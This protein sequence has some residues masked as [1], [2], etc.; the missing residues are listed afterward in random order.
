MKKFILP[1]FC[2][3]AFSITTFSQLQVTNYVNKNGIR[4]IAVKGDSV[5]IATT[6]GVVLRNIDGTLI[7]TYTMDEGLPHNDVSTVFA[8]S[9]GNIWCGTRGGVVKFDE[10]GMTQVSE[11]NNSTELIF[12]DNQGNIWF[13]RNWELIKY[14]GSLWTTYTTS[15]GLYYNY[16]YTV[17]EDNMG[18]M[19]FGYGYYE[20]GVTKFDGTNWTTYTDVDGLMNK[21]VYTIEEDNSG[22]M[23]FG[24]YGGGVSKFDGTNWIN[25]TSSDSLLGD[26]IYD[27]HKDGSGNLWFGINGAGINMYDGLTWSSFTSSDSL[28]SN[29]NSYIFEDSQGNLWFH[30]DYLDKFD[31]TQFTNYTTS[32]GL[33]GNG[34]YENKLAEDQT[35]NLWIGYS[36]NYKGLDK[37]D[38]STFI[39]Y[40]VDYNINS[41][42][43]YDIQK[44]HNGDLWFAVSGA[45]SLLKF[46]GTN[47]SYPGYHVGINTSSAY[48][49]IEDRNNNLW[50]GM[51]SNVAKWD[52]ASWTSYNETDGLTAKRIESMSQ[53]IAGNMWFGGRSSS[54]TDGVNKYDGVTW[55]TYTTA[56]GLDTSRV[57]ALLA[58]SLGNVWF[59][60]GYYGTGVTKYDGSAWTVITPANGIYSNSVFSILEDSKGNIW[61]GHDYG[62]SKFDG[63]TWTTFGSAEGFPGGYVYDITEDEFGVL[64]FAT[65]YGL[66]KYDSVNW[67]YYRLENS[68]LANNYLRAIEIDDQGNKWVGSGGYGLSV[69]SCQDP[70]ASFTYSGASYPDT[71]EFTNTSTL[72]DDFSRYEWDINDDGSIDYTTKNIKHVFMTPGTYQVQLVVLNDNCSDTIIQS[73]DVVDLS[74]KGGYTIGPSGD[75]ANFTDA[76]ND[77]IT[78]GVGG[79]VNFSVE[80]GNYNEQVVIPEISGASDTSTITFYPVNQHGAK[81]DFAPANPTENYTLKLDGADYISFEN[82]IISSSGTQYARVID[83]DNEASNNNFN[84]NQIIGINTE[85]LSNNRALV[86]S[87]TSSYDSINVF[88]NNTFKYGSYGIYFSCAGSGQFEYGNHI[89]GNEFLNQFYCALD[90]QYQNAPYVYNNT[91]T[92]SSTVSFTGIRLYGCT[93]YID[94]RK[95][96]ISALNS[97]GG[98]GLKFSN[99]NSSSGNEGLIANNFIYLNSTGSEC[100]GVKVDSSS[101]LNY[102][103]NTINITG[104]NTT[105]TCIYLNYT[106]SITTKNNIISNFAK[107]YTFYAGDSTDN[108][109]SDYNCLFTN[110]TFIGYTSGQNFADLA[111]LQAYNPAENQNCISVDPQYVS[112]TDLHVTNNALKA[113]TYVVDITTDIDGESRD[114]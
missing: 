36:N 16:V 49:L 80:D 111:A 26:Y 32:N 17:F 45:D 66:V 110:G 112:F 28:C 74:L 113:G 95:N 99:T 44:Y 91:I 86:Y 68:G 38:G 52:G 12:E 48:S 64:W 53:D 65:D 3:F 59:G 33:S 79:H 89:Y 71:V 93:D 14:D 50:F 83:M 8:D 4:G 46:D 100:Y 19:W 47:W 90:I 31:G 15:D 78:Y 55:T 21:M 97:G 27:I 73:I 98:Y 40:I 23:W 25:Y 42:Y 70:V 34:I 88:Q 1:F 103:F 51:Y 63:S 109:W 61:L 29:Y 30:G 11:V 35:G 104:N 76:V 77:L 101:C 18:N 92:T 69:I 81:L 57:Y 24:T 72:V 43:F 94:I 106:D 82:L 105:S 22:N 85:S 96:K 87:G 54:S 37:F 60:H 67:A 41:N 9:Q 2:F 13:A 108:I 5:W 7:A 39:N 6:G 62:L 114:T 56:D 58:D 102:Y 10:L 107:G 20:Y 84:N 75:Y